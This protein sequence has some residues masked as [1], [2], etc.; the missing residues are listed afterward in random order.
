MKISLLICLVGLAS[1]SITG[2]FPLAVLYGIDAMDQLPAFS[3][4][5]TEIGH[6]LGLPAQTLDLFKLGEY[7][8]GATYF[9]EA[10]AKFVDHCGEF[11]FEFK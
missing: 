1:C 5:K 3:L 11:S 10:V 7:V 8:H 9:A 6:S 4:C 2:T